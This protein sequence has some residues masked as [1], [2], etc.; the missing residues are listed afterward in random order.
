MNKLRDYWQ[1]LSAQDQ[2]IVSVLTGLIAALLLYTLVWQP[3]QVAR[4]RLE[5]NILQKQAQLLVMQTQ[6]KQ[7]Q[8]LRDAGKR[9]RDG[10]GNLQ[11]AVETSAQAH[12]IR[13][14]ITEL[15]L[16]EDGL[17]IRLP[18]VK[19]SDWITWAHALQTEHQI[20]IKS[21]SIAGLKQNGLVKVDAVLTA[22]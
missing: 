13:A 20:R 21:V 3:A 2:R 5:A 19:F 16:A 18:T 12:Q 7:I 15:Q 8:A 6:A 17:N 22:D 1:G 4:A 14:L 10:Q 11:T 9:L